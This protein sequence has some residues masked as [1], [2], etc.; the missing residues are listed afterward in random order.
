QASP[1]WEDVA[2]RQ[3]AL[4]RAIAL[5]WARWE[6]TPR[7]SRSLEVGGYWLGDRLPSG[8]LREQIASSR[9]IGRGMAL[10]WSLAQQ[11]G[12]ATRDQVNQLAAA[13]GVSPADYGAVEAPESRATTQLMQLRLATSSA[14][15][16][17]WIH[18]TREGR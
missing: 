13:F 8:N 18:L 16:D 12:R 11:D 1:L 5:S 3:A 2:A 4:Q 15:G 7:R 6:A 9:H 17:G 14:P 10:L